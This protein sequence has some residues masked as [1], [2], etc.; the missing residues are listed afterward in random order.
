[1]AKFLKIHPP[2][3][4]K[5]HK[6][7]V[8]FQDTLA[9]SKKKSYFKIKVKGKDNHP[10]TVIYTCCYGSNF[11]VETK[12]NLTGRAYEHENPLRRRNQRAYN[13]PHT[14]FGK[15]FL[16]ANYH[17]TEKSSILYQP[18]H[19]FCSPSREP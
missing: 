14:L 10:L 9:N 11:I 19:Q 2:L 3:S 15:G 4:S 7:P 6:Q 16:A 13:G 18:R 1:M 17:G 8:C 12:R 5:A